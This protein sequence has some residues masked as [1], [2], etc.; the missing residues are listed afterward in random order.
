MHFDDLKKILHL[1][2]TQNIQLSAKSLYITAGA[3]SKTLKKVENQLNTPLFDR[4]GRNIKLNAQGK[5]F[6]SYAVHLSHEYE[7]MCSEFSN[8]NSR[9]LLKVSGPAVLL[10]ACLKKIMPKLIDDR[11]ELSIDALY[12]G[13][14]LQQLING[15][16]HIAVVTNEV[17]DD[18]EAFGLSSVSLGT[19]QYE[20][21]AGN[22]HGIFTHYP[23]GVL[24]V[25]ALLQYPFVCSKTSPFCG[26][27]RGVGSDGWPDRQF[28]RK[29]LSRSDDL[30]A[31]LSIVNQNHMLAYIPD[32]LINNDRV[33]VI[34]LSEHSP[35]Y[36]EDYSLVYMPSNADGWLNRLINKLQ[37][38]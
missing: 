34:T 12:E 19:T 27:E 23:D 24:P 9:Y 3:L 22:E 11:I 35:Q 18:L 37:S 16:S 20:I 31:L 29:I 30:N 26:I 25:Q 15:Q 4:I 10:D 33:R 38:I 5:K 28:P 17:L 21:V 6:V 2:H 1:A 13:D 7:Q 14:A 32:L 36:A 8:S